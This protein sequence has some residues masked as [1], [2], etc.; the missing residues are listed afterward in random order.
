[1][2][3]YN[4]NETDDDLSVSDTVA[5]RIS[6]MPDGIYTVETY[7][8]DRENNNT[9]RAWQ[10]QGSPETSGDA[11]LKSLEEAAELSVTDSSNERSS[12]GEMVLEILLPRH[13]MKLIEIK[14]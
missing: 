11:D 8:M 5:I 13:S 3:V 14:P 12:D 6:G 1:M 2:L 4:Y 9:Y 7:S 10:K